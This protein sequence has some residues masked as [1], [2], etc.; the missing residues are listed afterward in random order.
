MGSREAKGLI[1]RYLI[2]DWSRLD[3]F[4]TPTFSTYFAES[5]LLGCL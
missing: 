1:Q 5:L 4:R 2:L 3:Q